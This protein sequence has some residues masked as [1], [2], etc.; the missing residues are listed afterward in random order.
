M[1]RGMRKD[2]E[3]SEAEAAAAIDKVV[4]RLQP[5]RG[6]LGV[7]VGQ[8][9]RQALVDHGPGGFPTGARFAHAAHPYTWSTTEEFT[10]R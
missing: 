9:R 8:L 5:L 2:T 6:L 7:D 1:H 3:V 10:Q 4:E